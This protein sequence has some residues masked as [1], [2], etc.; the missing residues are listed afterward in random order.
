MNDRYIPRGAYEAAQQAWGLLG[1]AEAQLR[2]GQMEEGLKGLQVALGISPEIVGEKAELRAAIASIC[3]S[4]VAQMGP[5][6]RNDAI[7]LVE[8]TL[9]IVGD[10]PELQSA[11]SEL[12]GPGE[13]DGT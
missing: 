3:L 7:T 8:G 13:S 5:T 1:W 6:E 2:Q 10:D 9:A 4:T 12:R 11:I